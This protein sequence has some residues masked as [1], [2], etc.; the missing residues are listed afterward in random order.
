M[1]LS[2]RKQRLAKAYSE[3]F[4]DA[5]VPLPVPDMSRIPDHLRSDALP[6]QAWRSRRFI[7][8][9]WIE[10][11]GHRRLTIHRAEIDPKTGENMDG[12]TWDELQRLKSEAGFHDVCAVEIYPPDDQVIYEHNMRHLWLLDQAPAFMWSNRNA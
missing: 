8:A 4:T 5:L 12:I 2:K 11:N 1:K 9:L 3:T 6:L 10:T 7:V